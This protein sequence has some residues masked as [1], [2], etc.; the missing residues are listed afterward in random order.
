MKTRHLPPPA[1]YDLLDG[2][3]PLN[4]EMKSHLDECPAC[5]QVLAQLNELAAALSA[6]PPV[7]AA[8]SPP[9]VLAAIARQRPLLPLSCGWTAA[10]VTLLALA[11]IVGPL[12]P[13]SPSAFVEAGVALAALGKGL[14]S[15]AAALSD[16]LLRALPGTLLVT[17]TAALAAASIAITWISA[18][19]LPAPERPRGGQP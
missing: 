1:L 4:A 3:R 7:A 9:R 15:I 19:A 6:P 10:A 17:L 5:R 12:L 18:R 13:T 2:E 8:I 16:P 11:G 14:C